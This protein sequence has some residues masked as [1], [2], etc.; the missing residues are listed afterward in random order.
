MKRGDGKSE[1]VKVSNKTDPQKE[2]SWS[3]GGDVLGV[4]EGIALIRLPKIT[5]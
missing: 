1:V 2:A 3:T 5:K 4:K